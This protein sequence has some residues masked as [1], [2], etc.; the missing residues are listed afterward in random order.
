MDAGADDMN[1]FSPRL[2]LRGKRIAFLVANGFDQ[3][4]LEKPRQVLTE[5][6]ALTEIISVEH[7]EVRGWDQNQPGNWFAV[8]TP[9]AQARDRDYDAL[10]LPGGV[11]SPDRLRAFPEAIRF[12]RSFLDAR[13]PTAAI[14]H[15][16]QLL[17][18][19][20]IVRGRR[21]T[22]HPAI[23]TD[24]INAGAKWTDEPVVVDREL[25]TS[26]RAD[27]LPAFNDALLAAIGEYVYTA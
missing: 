14:C 6:G 21:L 2:E 10:L 26:R 15:G 27:D 5:V 24:L 8:D 19:A 3:I 22:S 20:G 18:E 7:R 13:K 16:P 25:I 17:I 23:K 1:G 4:E 12:V 11:M 9:L